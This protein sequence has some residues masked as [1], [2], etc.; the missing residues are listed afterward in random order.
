MPAATAGA[1]DREVGGK[2]PPRKARWFPHSWS[3]DAA[4][5]RQA[6]GETG[7]VDLSS[8]HDFGK[9]DTLQLSVPTY[10][11]TFLRGG[12]EKWRSD[13]QTHQLLAH[14]RLEAY[15]AIKGEKSQ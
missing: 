5:E 3:G 6:P 13:M 15:L 9:T 4:A 11:S 8:Q 14:F 12:S 7:Q 10:L 1:P 2:F